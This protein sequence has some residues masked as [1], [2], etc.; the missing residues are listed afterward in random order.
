MT[1]REKLAIEHPDEV[2]EDYVGGCAGCPYDHGY[3]EQPS[4]CPKISCKECWDREIPEEPKKF[5]D[6]VE[7]IAAHSS[8]ASRFEQ[9]AEEAVELAHAAQKIARYLRGEQPVAEDFDLEK[10]IENLVEEYADVSLAVDTVNGFGD[11]ILK[12][13]N[14]YYDA[15]AARWV[16]RL[17]E[18][19]QKKQEAADER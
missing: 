13:W 4:D 8:K 12:K 17:K 7:Y 11:E 5:K 2:S 9:L 16:K 3:L 10:T 6:P 15:K 14:D 18:A 19:E 1:Y